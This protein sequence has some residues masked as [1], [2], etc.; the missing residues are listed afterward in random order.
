MLEC[1]FL[2]KYTN[3]LKPSSKIGSAFMRD[4]QG[5][6]QVLQLVRVFGIYPTI[7][8]TSMIGAIHLTQEEV[9]ET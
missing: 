3:L 9:K 7:M 8:L 4:L 6:Q 2:N 1:Q 5:Q